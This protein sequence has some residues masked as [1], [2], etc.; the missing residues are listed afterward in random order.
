MKKNV[1]T[2]DRVIRVVAALALF[3]L[4]LLY[5]KGSYGYQLA[6]VGFFIFVTATFA[7]CPFYK[8]CLIDT[9]N[10]DKR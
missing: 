1:G 3:C 8:I 4:G 10:K 7:F 6:A 5:F 2:I 9:Q